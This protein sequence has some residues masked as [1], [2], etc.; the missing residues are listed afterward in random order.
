MSRGDRAVWE[1]MWSPYDESTYRQ[2]LSHVGPEDVV[3]D[4]GA[5]DLRLDRRLARISA[6]VFCV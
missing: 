6:R 4:I 3:V 1:A 2:V 5:G